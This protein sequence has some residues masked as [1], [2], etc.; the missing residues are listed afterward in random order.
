MVTARTYTSDAQC[1]L[2]DTKF[3]LPKISVLP[4]T[5][6][7]GISHAFSR[8]TANP[9]SVLSALRKH[10][11]IRFRDVIRILIFSRGRDVAC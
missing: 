8:S 10:S 3:D 9:A 1:H 5:Q 7:R 4:A 2:S 11:L 6:S